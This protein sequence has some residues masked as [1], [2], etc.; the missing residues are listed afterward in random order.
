MY[1]VGKKKPELLN[2]KLDSTY[3][4]HYALKIKQNQ[5][6]HGIGGRVKS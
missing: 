2:V 4:Y 6:K 3:T 1:S 5:N